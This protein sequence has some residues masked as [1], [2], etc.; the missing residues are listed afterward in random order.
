MSRSSKDISTTQFFVY[1]SLFSVLFA[2]IMLMVFDPEPRT[3]N[4][5]MGRSCT[6]KGLSCNECA[7]TAEEE[8]K[9]VTEATAKVEN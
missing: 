6:E 4:M 7:C 5:T 3:G 2:L 8:E 1:G 9:A